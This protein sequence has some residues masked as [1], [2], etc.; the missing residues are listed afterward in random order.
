MIDLRFLVAFCLL[1]VVTPVFGQS[2]PDRGT[3]TSATRATTPPSRGA[4]EG[5]VTHC[6]LTDPT[7]S[8][9]TQS[10][11][12]VS[13]NL[14][15]SP[16]G[17]VAV[18]NSARAGFTLTPQDFGAKGDGST[19]DSGAINA[20]FAK[21]RSLLIANPKLGL[22]FEIP[23]AVY[24]IGHGVNAT[25]LQVF[26]A[27]APVIIE[28]HGAMLDCQPSSRESCF[29]MIGSAGIIVRDISIYGDPLQGVYP[30][31]GFQMGEDQYVNGFP[32]S[33]D[34]N[35]IDNLHV[36]G[37]F[38]LAACYNLASETATF[39]HPSCNNSIGTGTNNY[40][41]IIDGI[42]HFGLTSAYQTIKLPVDTITSLEQTVVIG[43][44][45]ANNSG[46]PV[47]WMANSY[48]ARFM[49]TYFLTQHSQP[50]VVL[51]TDVGNIFN[52]LFDIHTEN[53]T[54][55]ETFLITGRPGREPATISGLSYID[56]YGFANM[57]VF[58]KDETITSVNMPNMTVHVNAFLKS[59]VPL[60]DTPSAYT[61]TGNIT[62][63]SAANWSE[64][65][66]F[67][68]LK[69]LGSVGYIDSTAGLQNKGR[70]VLSLPAGDVSSIGVGGNNG[71]RGTTGTSNSLFGVNAGAALTTGG[72]NTA[73]GADALTQATA[74]GGSTAVGF[75]AC[76]QSSSGHNNLCLGSVTGSRT[77]MGSNDTLIGGGS[78]V[79]V[80]GASD[81]INIQGLLFYNANSIAAPGVAS[82]GT[83]PTIDSHANNRSGTVTA[84][85]GSVTRC[86]IAFAGSGYNSWNHCRVTSQDNVAGFAYR[87]TLSDI[88]VTA[89]G[90]LSRDKI[91]YDCDGY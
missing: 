21:G 63:P 47:L 46:G 19:D 53:T 26:P 73:V 84:G 77:A 51:Y 75:S 29:D 45:I 82:C 8:G 18:T 69:T 66:S 70:S 50:A 1:L 57:S 6:M 87:Y 68:G 83:S 16:N 65:A 71:T 86:R 56:N 78:N 7:V 74:G 34:N 9:G 48:G 58:K 33:A 67:T 40:G 89:A 44:E 59:T 27:N 13:G 10:G 4:A 64:P 54:E 15:K 43:G 42:N 61:V 38:S 31:T 2:L 35:T 24:R 25:N 23:Q 79:A 37:L 60:F 90:S 20:M 12:D 55:P 41:M 30:T 36:A 11:A 28:G 85:A 14:V 39:Y 32:V 91:D 80:P 88:T 5:C 22:K 76:S 49:G 81:E 72:S 3:V 62:L 52:P 17:S